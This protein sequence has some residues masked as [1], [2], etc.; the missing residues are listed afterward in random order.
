MTRAELKPSEYVLHRCAEPG[1]GAYA[2]GARCER[3]ETP[4]DRARLTAMH[5]ALLRAAELEEA[6]LD[7]HWAA[8]E[9]ERAAGVRRARPGYGRS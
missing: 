5:T 1:C 7:A 2:L 8:L 6:W 9:A 3:H 4:D